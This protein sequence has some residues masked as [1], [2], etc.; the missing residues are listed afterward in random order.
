MQAT[1]RNIVLIAAVAA[2]VG[3]LLLYWLVA[4]QYERAHDPP[5]ASSAPAADSSKEAQVEP[6][7]PRSETKTETPP[8]TEPFLLPPVNEST[9]KPAPPEEEDSEPPDPHAPCE[10]MEDVDA[11]DRCSEEVDTRIDQLIEGC[12][13]YEDPEIWDACME[14]A[15]AAQ[16]YRPG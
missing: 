6:A 12:E 15:Q 8:A 13:R 1:P 16:D 2:A 5:A 4:A 11:A 14:A 9:P 7:L 3:G 10:A